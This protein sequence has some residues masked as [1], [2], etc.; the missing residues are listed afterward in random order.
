MAGGYICILGSHTGTLYIGVTATCVCNPEF[1]DFVQTW[2]WRMIQVHE[3][4]YWWTIKCVPPEDPVLGL[5]SSK[6]SERH[7]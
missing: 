2:G 1:K 3:K 6:S 7:R 4:M 5:R